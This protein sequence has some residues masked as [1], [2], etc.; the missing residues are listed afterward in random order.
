MSI[1]RYVLPMPVQGAQKRSVMYDGAAARTALIKFVTFKPYFTSQCLL[2]EGVYCN[3]LGRCAVHGRCCRGDCV[4]ITYEITGQLEVNDSTPQ[5]ALHML[6][7]IA[8]H[9]VTLPVAAP[10]IMIYAPLALLKLHLISLTRW[11][12][13]TPCC[14]QRHQADE[15]S[16]CVN[17][18]SD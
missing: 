3:A 7:S 1:R 11:T 9:G 10:H 4:C 17:T 13:I 16:R 5:L 6:T 15:T 12:Y 8:C 14:G 18:G 2:S